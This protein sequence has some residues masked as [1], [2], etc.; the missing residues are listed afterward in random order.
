MADL[1]KEIQFIK[2][3]GPNRAALLNKLGIFKN[4]YF[5]G[6]N[7]YSL[8]LQYNC[9]RQKEDKRICQISQLH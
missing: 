9:D 3:V 8:V 6:C 4:F 2:G 5:R 7:L 1:K